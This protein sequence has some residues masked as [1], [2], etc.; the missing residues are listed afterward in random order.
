[1]RDSA[2]PSLK[3]TIGKTMKRTPQPALAQSR[4][5]SAGGNLR[6]NTD[7]NAVSGSGGQPRSI[8]PGPLTDNSPAAPAAPVPI[9]TISGGGSLGGGT[10]LEPLTAD[11]FRKLIGENTDR[12]T[13]KIDNMAPD[14]AALTRTVDMNKAEISKGAEETKRQADLI[15][16]HKEMIDRLGRRVDNLESGGS[17]AAPM[18]S[19]GPRPV[20]APVKSDRYLRARRSV[21]LWPINQA[22]ENSLWKGVGEFIHTA[23]GISEDDICQEDIEAVVPIPDPRLPVGNLNSEALVTFFCQRNRDTILARVSS[24]STYVDGAGKPTA[25]VRLEVP[26]ELND[27]FRLLSRFGTRLRARHGEGTRRHI[28]FDDLEAS[29]YMNIKLPGDEEWS[30]VTPEMAKIDLGETARADSARVLKRIGVPTISGPRQ[31][32]AAPVIP[33]AAGNTTEPKTNNNTGEASTRAGPPPR[34]WA[35]VTRTN[36]S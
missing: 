22:D 6:L 24:L 20:D 33:S 7:S 28:K 21:R 13:K 17:G 27:T 35:P 11:F 16:E 25:G 34:A 30:R 32:L 23:L 3:R 18:A 4:L 26:P 15:K 29:M 2:S 36:Q 1:M 31:R 19:V 14:L 12:V 9:M 5:T 8:E 10:E